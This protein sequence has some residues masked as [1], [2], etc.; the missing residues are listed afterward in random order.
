MTRSLRRFP[1]LLAAALLAAC[2]SGPGA[3]PGAAP[4]P[5]P[6][7]GPP[8]YP[9]ASGSWTG[10]LIVEGQPIDGTLELGQDGGDLTAL[11]AAPAMGV[12]AE[13]GGT[14]SREGEVRIL[15]DYDVQCPGSAELIGTLGPGGATL[16]GILEAGDCTGS[17]SG[18]FEFHR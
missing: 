8:D 18:S 1:S 13:G 14:I 6:E 10:S 2:S 4:D 15:L 17:T 5:A 12:T 7:A 3:G 9:E 16:A 11:L